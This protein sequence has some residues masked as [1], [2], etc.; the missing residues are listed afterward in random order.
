MRR[1]EVVAIRNKIP[2]DFDVALGCEG[3]AMD[4]RKALLKLVVEE[5]GAPVF[6]AGF[7]AR[8]SRLTLHVPAGYDVVELKSQ[9][10]SVIDK[11]VEPIR[12]SVRAHYRSQLAFPRSL[13]RWLKRFD[14][15]DVT[16]APALLVAWALS[17]RLVAKSSR[18]ALGGAISELLFDPELRTL[19]VLCRRKSDDATMSALRMRVAT[20]VDDVW[21]RTAVR[22]EHG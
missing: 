8:G 6:L 22:A 1:V 20:I 12:I 10:A 14:V 9:A 17:L 7:D 18:S 13:E 16:L 5:L 15:G 21:D 3:F 4:N 19:F 11:A 2:Y